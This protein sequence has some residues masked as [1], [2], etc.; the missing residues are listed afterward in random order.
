[1]KRY[2]I[3]NNGLA[4]IANII[5]EDL[6]HTF[7][8]KNASMDKDDWEGVK[9]MIIEWLLWFYKDM[10]DRGEITPNMTPR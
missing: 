7:R 10:A 4:R 8:A 5:L 1:M 9:E 3:S 6:A 2:G